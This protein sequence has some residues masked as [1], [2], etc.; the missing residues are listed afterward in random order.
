MSHHLKTGRGMGLQPGAFTHLN[1]QRQVSGQFMEADDAPAQVSIGE[2]DIKDRLHEALYKRATRLDRLRGLIVAWV[3]HGFFIIVPRKHN[4][5]L[6]VRYPAL[7]DPFTEA[8]AT[9]RS[10]ASG[11]PTSEI[12][13]TAVCSTHFTIPINHRVVTGPQMI[14]NLLVAMDE[15]CDPED[16][17]Q[18]QPSVHHGRF[19]GL[20]SPSSNSAHRMALVAVPGVKQSHSFP[21]ETRSFIVS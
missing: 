2:R 19:A 7:S 13:G 20:P 21:D 9:A 11:K 14:L 15:L 1:K 4:G 10:L 16:G 18:L 8:H 6:V 3:D 5:R 12:L 17:S